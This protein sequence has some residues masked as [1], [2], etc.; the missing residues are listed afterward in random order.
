MGLGEETGC[1]GFAVLVLSTAS[2]TREKQTIAGKETSWTR[3]ESWWDHFCWGKKM[4][5]KSGILTKW[6]SWRDFRHPGA[7]RLRG[8]LTQ[9][10]MLSW[11][12]SLGVGK[13]VLQ[14]P[15]P[16][17]AAE[18]VSGSLSLLLLTR[19]CRRIPQKAL[20]TI[21][22]VG[23][24]PY[25]Q[26]SGRVVRGK[27][28]WEQVRWAESQ[29]TSKSSVIAVLRELWSQVKTTKSDLFCWDRSDWYCGWN[30]VSPLLQPQPFLAILSCAP[31]T[32]RKTRCVGSRDL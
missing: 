22:L 12:V 7:A 18:V 13:A 26:R 20:R 15:V 21:H 28:V 5:E 16:V 25:F 24:G 29:P 32:P 6:A 9:R 3:A 23:K 8:Q 11:L 14:R 10:Q 31:H 1:W 17:G 19:G 27:R 2:L 30:S 4:R